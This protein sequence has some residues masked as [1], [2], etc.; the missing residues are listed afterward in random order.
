MGTKTLE[1]PTYSLHALEAPIPPLFLKSHFSPQLLVYFEDLREGMS[2]AGLFVIKER[3]ASQRN[4]NKTVS[5]HVGKR[6]KSCENYQEKAYFLCFYF[7]SF[8]LLPCSKDTKSQK[9]RL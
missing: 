1:C 9:G 5:V 6:S 4:G 3:V 2:K 7:P 8:I